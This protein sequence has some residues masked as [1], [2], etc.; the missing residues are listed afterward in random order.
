MERAH[1]FGDIQS[2]YDIF[3][4]FADRKGS[5]YLERLQKEFPTFDYDDERSASRKITKVVSWNNTNTVG[6]V[7]FSSPSQAS[8]AV[9]TAST[10]AEKV[11][12]PAKVATNETTAITKTLS[13][14]DP[15]WPARIFESM[16]NSAYCFVDRRLT[17]EQDLRLDE[18][19]DALYWTA[20][21]GS[22]VWKFNTVTWQVTYPDGVTF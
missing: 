6:K 7:K 22:R 14:V 5:I 1:Q 13:E 9:S 19:S 16:I 8:M 20:T 3:R 10:G 21:Y 4:D 2:A 17:F 12:P 18:S 15:M 11:I